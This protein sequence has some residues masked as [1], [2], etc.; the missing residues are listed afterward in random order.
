MR[1]RLR[2]VFLKQ[3]INWMLHGS[4]EDPAEEFFVRYHRTNNRDNALQG[5]I[6]RPI[7]ADNMLE[8]AYS[9]AMY[10]GQN[11][12]HSHIAG[13]QKGGDL[14]FDWVHSYELKL[15]MLPESLLSSRM[16]LKLLFAGKAVLLIQS[17]KR[18]AIDGDGYGR[19]GGGDHPYPGLGQELQSDTF[20]YLTADASNASFARG[21]VRF[22]VPPE[23][24]GPQVLPPHILRRPLESLP[25]SSLVSSAETSRPRSLLPA[26]DLP[27]GAGPDKDLSDPESMIDQQLT[28][29]LAERG[30]QAADLSR[31]SELFLAAARATEADRDAVEALVDAVSHTASSNL[32]SLLKKTFRFVSFLHLF[33]NVYLQGRGEWM[34]AI[35]DGVTVVVTEVAYSEQ[36]S[37]LSLL[38]AGLVRD[39][40]RMLQLDPEDMA[41]LVQLRVDSGRVYVNDFRGD[42]VR[43]EGGARG[44]FQALPGGS[45]YSSRCLLSVEDEA[46][47]KDTEVNRWREEWGRM[48]RRG[49]DGKVEDNGEERLVRSH[50]LRCTGCVWLS[51]PKPVAKGFRVTATF[52]LPADWRDQFAVHLNNSSASGGV[53]VGN[54]GGAEGVEVGS[55]ALVLRE[56]GSAAVCVPGISE[57]GGRWD[58]QQRVSVSASFHARYLVVTERSQ[59]HGQEDT[60]ADASTAMQFFCRVTIFLATPPTAG[61]TSRGGARSDTPRATGVGVPSGAG[62]VLAETV[63][64]LSHT[65]SYSTRDFTRRCLNADETL[66]LEADYSREL[67]PSGAEDASGRSGSGVVG[68]RM[69]ARVREKGVRGAASSS[70]DVEGLVDI[71]QALRLEGGCAAIGVM[72]TGLCDENYLLSRRA[73]AQPSQPRA[74]QPP[75]RKRFSVALH[76]VDFTSKQGLAATSV[77]AISVTSERLQVLF[78]DVARRVA[79][80]VSALNLWSALT[81]T[82]FERRGPAENQPRFAILRYDDVGDDDDELRLTMHILERLQ[83]RAPSSRAK[84]ESSLHN[85]LQRTFTHLRHSMLFFVSNLLVYFQ[86]DVIASEYNELLEG[87]REARDLQLVMRLHRNFIASIV[88]LTMVENTV[89]QDGLERVLQIIYR[90]VALC[91]AVTSAENVPR[92]LLYDELTYVQADY[93]TQISFLFQIIRWI[94]NRGL[95]TRLDFNNHFSGE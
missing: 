20:R 60:E 88:K 4:L 71:S 1:E 7:S 90:F 91:W 81:T 35:L 21:S 9:S 49:R 14:A 36:Q 84:V 95:L 17:A 54:G 74:P 72:G 73:P 45:G 5:G 86:T 38:T 10:R 18:M 22:T 26:E 30:F 55:I 92:D 24:T 13:V 25:A 76:S 29:N 68:Y 39:S 41:R 85:R 62:T 87:V 28:A 79:D 16:A 53:G 82:A 33:R 19:R 32:W 34:Q 47:E 2:V 89:T 70:W 64:E 8:D 78:P 56:S 11:A 52:T 94:E 43:L 50:G 6:S 27:V 69:R 67:A 40:C 77:S 59:G 65:S 93:A 23:S 63:F 3:S 57:E 48:I 31:F 44:S 46:E 61:S 15:D 42:E 51:T 37:R 12:A 80:L 83:L 58:Y 75:S 66:V